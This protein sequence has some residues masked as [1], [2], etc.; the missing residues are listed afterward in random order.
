MNNA[1]ENIPAEILDDI[2]LTLK[3]KYGITIIFYSNN[4]CCYFELKKKFW[5]QMYHM[6]K[7]LSSKV[8]RYKVVKYFDHMVEEINE[9]EDEPYLVNTLLD[10]FYRIFNTFITNVDELCKNTTSP[11]DSTD[12]IIETISKYDIYHIHN[13]LAEIQKY[14]QCE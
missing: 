9:E 1:N 6:H 8:V 10:T 13:K 14:I 12:E 7:E 2:R 4:E 5:K 11:D 3:K